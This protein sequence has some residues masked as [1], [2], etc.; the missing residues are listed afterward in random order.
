VSF[1]TD[2]LHNRCLPT[3]E[4]FRDVGCGPRT[5]FVLVALIGFPRTILI[6]AAGASFGIG[7]APIA[8]VAGAAGGALACLLSR[9]IA[10]DWF[11]RKLGQGPYLCF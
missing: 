9:C 7:A 5:I 1:E 3:G 2:K 4:P 11:R 6:I 8:L 10:A